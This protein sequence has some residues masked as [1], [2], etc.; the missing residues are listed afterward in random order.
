MHLPSTCAVTSAVSTVFTVGRT[1]E[2]LVAVVI[3]ATVVTGVGSE[4]AAP[5]AIK[6]WMLFSVPTEIATGKMC[7]DIFGN[8]L[9]RWAN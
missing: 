9:S 5:P 6:Q 3:L 7:K 2:Y 8:S 4:D 1:G